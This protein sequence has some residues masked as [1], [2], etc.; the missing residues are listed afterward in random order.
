MSIA[1]KLEENLEEL[2]EWE[3]SSQHFACT[4]RDVAFEY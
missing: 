2:W 1:R 4:F 3:L